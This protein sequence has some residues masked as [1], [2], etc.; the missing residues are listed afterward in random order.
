MA[1]LNNRD[2]VKQT[3]ST[4]GT[5]ALS[6]DAT[7]PTGFQGFVAAVG[8]G[9]QAHYFIVDSAGLWETGITTV[10]DATPDTLSRSAGTVLDGSSGPGVLVSLGAGTKDVV[11][12]ITPLRSG[13]APYS[14]WD[15]VLSS[16]DG[17]NV[18]AMNGKTGQRQFTGTNWGTIVNSILDETSDSYA[19]FLA[20]DLPDSTGVTILIDKSNVTLWC[21]KRNTKIGAGTAS[22]GNPPAAKPR[23]RTIR[24]GGLN[25]SIH[26]IW[27]RGIRADE[28]D[29]HAEGN[30]QTWQEDL[31]GVTLEG[32]YTEDFQAT[33][34]RGLRFSGG[35]DVEHVTVID[36]FAEVTSN[37]TSETDP[38]HY[39]SF[40]ST[41]LGTGHI[42]FLNFWGENSSGFTNISGIVYKNGGMSGPSVRF[43]GSLVFI[44]GTPTGCH[45][46]QTHVGTALQDAGPVTFQ[47]L[48]LHVECQN[49]AMDIWR[50]NDN[51]ALG[52]YFGVLVTYIELTTGAF[53]YTWCNQLGNQFIG[54]HGLRV[55]SGLITFSYTSF[56]RG[57]N[58]DATFRVRIKDVEGW[59]EAPTH[60]VMTK[61]ITAADYTNSTTT[62]TEVTALEVPNLHPGTYRFSYFLIVQTASTSTGVGF[63]VNFTGTVTRIVNSMRYTS[64]AT[65]TTTGV[66]EDIV[67]NNL[68]AMVEGSTSRSVSTTAPNLG[69]IAGVSASNQDHL[70]IIEGV[71]EVS[72]AG[73]LELWARS[74]VSSQM[75]VEIG[76]NVV[77]TRMT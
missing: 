40:E 18:H 56:G 38:K 73:N 6:L 49:A 8:N 66:I 55:T 17:V 28:I 61:A 14:G 45:V 63:G 47:F 37:G 75:S 1:F 13:L 60:E 22:G 50:V 74:E 68:G 71:V 23:V 48:S 62:G 15:W 5:G 64:T 30:V 19:I 44:G 41:S 26:R 20:P 53:A 52:A 34:R 7:V 16:P 51:G 43:S 4:T 67:A 29:L 24:T 39:I 54:D 59:D 36:H 77:V 42:E 31:E 25:L 65:T 35:G 21:P 69:P 58:A 33:D 76:S 57:S 12:G 72:A 10:T 70:V 32:C 11:C 2:R 3:T 27:L 9:N 46:M